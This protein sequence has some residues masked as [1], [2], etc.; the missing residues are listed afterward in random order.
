[1]FWTVAAIGF[2]VLVALAWIRAERETRAFDD[3]VEGSEL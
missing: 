1:M 3:Q 2:C